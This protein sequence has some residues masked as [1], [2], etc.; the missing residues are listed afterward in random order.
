VF[1]P[2]GGTFSGLEIGQL[3]NVSGD[4]GA[5]KCVFAAVRVAMLGLTPRH[6]GGAGVKQDESRRE[7]SHWPRA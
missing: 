7:E 4:L 1:G 5:A 3:H 6:Q 2:D